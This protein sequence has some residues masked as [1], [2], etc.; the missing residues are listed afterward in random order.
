MDH[1]N[2]RVDSDG[3][4]TRITI[5]RPETR[6]ACTMPMWPALRDAFLAVPGSGARVVVLTGAGSD[7]CSGA[8]VSRG[9]RGDFDGN[10]LDAMHIV[11]QSVLAIHECPVP[12]IA[13]V[14][15]VAVGAGLGLALACDLTYCTDRARFSA[16]FAKVGLSLDYG[17]SWFLAQ[18]VGLHVA[19]EM[20]L[21][22]EMITAQRAAEIGFVN[23][24]VPADELD[25]T[26]DGIVERIVT[27][28]PSAL[29]MTKRLLD[30]AATWSLRQALDAEGLSQTINLASEDTKE[31]FRAF[32]DKR[33]PQFTG[34]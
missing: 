16:I 22:A 14:D 4:V 25:S 33:P 31:A 3:P 15:G 13:R 18:R 28:P 12:V 24:V 6:N 23:A 8:D 32:R 10:N 27:G 17:T 29:T 20:A 11:G 1:E 19:K 7:F 21:T 9:G 5:D 2:I 34:R 26:I 30:H